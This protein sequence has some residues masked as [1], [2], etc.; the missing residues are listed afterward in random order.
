M[1][2]MAMMAVPFLM[3]WNPDEV[4]SIAVRGASQDRPALRL[5]QAQGIQSI[6]STIPP[7]GEL[8]AESC[9]RRTGCWDDLQEFLEEFQPV[10]FHNLEIRQSFF[11]RLSFGMVVW[12]AFQLR[13]ARENSGLSDFH[14]LEKS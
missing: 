1:V 4:N 11:N 5:E 14:E 13:A 6:R 12:A 9:Q 8:P 2:A 10:S 3:R 7:G